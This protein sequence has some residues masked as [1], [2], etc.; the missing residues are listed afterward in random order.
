MSI[1]RSHS[2]AL[3]IAASA[4]GL[5]DPPAT[6]ATAADLAPALRVVIAGG[7]TGGHLFPGIAIAEEIC[8]RRPENR[9]LFISR[10]NDF[11]RRALARAGFDLEPVTAEGLK[12]R[13]P[14]NQLRALWRLPA[15]ILQAAR[16]LGGFRPDLV[17]GLGSY[18]AGPVVMAAWLKR[19]PI[20]LCEQN[21]LPGVAN[22]VLARTAERIY[23]AFEKTERFDPQ[24]TLWTGNP[25]RREIAR[26]V[27]DRS[28]MPP[29][30]SCPERFTVLI[31]GG[32][33][34]AHSINRAVAAALGELRRAERIFCVHQTGAADEEWVR[35]AYREAAVA[36]RVQAFF[37]DMAEIY[38]KA[39]L[40]VCRAG[41]STVAE[42]TA[43]G[44]AAI[45]IPYPHA[46]DDHQRLNARRLADAG[47]AEWI[48]EKELSG[49]LLGERILRHAADP[50][51]L[52]AMAARAALLGK[53]DAAQR[54]VDDCIR[55]AAQRRRANPSTGRPA[56]RQTG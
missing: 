1:G 9:V 16:L 28:G 8:G 44:K 17:V 29:A 6:A 22:R 33:Q 47:A 20:V 48:D 34:G 24:K 54:I 31:I 41:A 15:G 7:G 11:E 49:A 51:A 39:D 30:A 36:A 18:A 13:G 19:I 46:A 12:G 40:I 10:G 4:G 21:T 26:A 37:D 56:G 50:Q 2:L 53:P 5:A 25:L 32:S 23:T 55:I 35:E 38:R 3:Q 27:R 14:W 43:L 45:Y 52:R 42:I